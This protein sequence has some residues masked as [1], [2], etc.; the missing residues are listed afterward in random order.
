MA[1]GHLPIYINTYNIIYVYEG[2]E[3]G[4]WGA[5][6]TDAKKL[7]DLRI[8]VMAAHAHQIWISKVFLTKLVA[9]NRHVPLCS[10]VGTV[11]G[12]DLIRGNRWKRVLDCYV[13]SNININIGGMY[14][15]YR[16]TGI[17][18]GSCSKSTSYRY[19]Y[20]YYYY[21]SPEGWRNRGL[22]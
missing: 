16:A 5:N 22:G 17:Q 21:I 2:C 19:I 14:H 4:T 6:E 20:T 1:S 13:P 9:V 18:A 12:K 7:T 3:V 8:I 11:Y 10:P 15:L